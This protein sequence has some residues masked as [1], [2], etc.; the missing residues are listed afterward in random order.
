MFS[1]WF[2]RKLTH[3]SLPGSS[4]KA[5]EDCVDRNPSCE[6]WASKGEC[7][8]NPGWMIVNCAKRYFRLNLYI[9]IIN[10]SKSLSLSLSYIF[11]IHGYFSCMVNVLFPLVVIPFLTHASFVMHV[12]VAL[13][14]I[15][16]SQ[17]RPS[18]PLV[19]W[20]TCSAPSW[21]SSPTDMRSRSTL[22]RLG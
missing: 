22:L 4:R 3:S 2:W 18:M 10:I 20:T 1:L 19:T 7:H 13:E 8:K 5:E 9:Y 15:S 21:I 11:N 6:S 17:L 16:T 14:N 12:S